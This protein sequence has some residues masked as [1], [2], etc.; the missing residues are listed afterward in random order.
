MNKKV[1]II[2][3]IVLTILI[4]TLWLG[5]IIPKQIAKIYASNYMKSNFPEMELKY[6][7]IEWNKYYGDY[8]I[9]FKDKNNQSYSCV[10]GPKYFPVSMGQGMYAIE[11]TYRQNYSK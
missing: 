9:T 11:E 3:I 7:N 5:G 2:T 4:I 8:T 10:I 6:V 1:I